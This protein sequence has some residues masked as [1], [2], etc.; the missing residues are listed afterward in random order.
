VAI[1]EAQQQGREAPED[2]GKAQEV[3]AQAKEQVQARAGEVKGKASARVRE[4]LDTRST[5]MGEQVGSFGEALRKAAEHLQGQ[6]NE[7]GARAAHQ[8]AHQAERLGGYLTNSSS[9]RFLG[10]VE[11]FGR[12]R[13]WVA[14]AIGA[15]LGFVGARFVKASSERRYDA[16][17]QAHRDADLPLGRERD[18]TAALPQTPEYGSR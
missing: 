14:G 13:P 8:A 7:S 5:Q 2:S 15:A 4:Q 11:R 3:A 9:D 12:Q 1:D 18:A 17:Y 6:G 10:D 16:S